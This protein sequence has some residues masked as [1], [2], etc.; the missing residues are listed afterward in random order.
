M[1][2]VQLR[3]FG[4]PLGLGMG[5]LDAGGTAVHKNNKLLK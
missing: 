1:L 2:A 5:I 3:T 4:S